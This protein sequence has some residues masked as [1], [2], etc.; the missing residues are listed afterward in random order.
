MSRLTAARSAMVVPRRAAG[1]GL[2]LELDRARTVADRRPLPH[3]R[4]RR[5]GEVHEDLALAAHQPVP[6]QHPADPRLAP[7]DQQRDDDARD[8]SGP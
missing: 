1:E 2:Q 5:R 4:Q 6:V 8:A 3:Q 7:R